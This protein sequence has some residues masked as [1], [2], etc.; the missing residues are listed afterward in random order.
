HS[1]PRPTPPAARTAARSW[2]ATAAATSAS[3]AGAP[4]AA[5]EPL[6]RSTS[7]ASAMRRGLAVSGHEPAK[8]AGAYG[9]FGNGSRV[10]RPDGKIA[11]RS[12]GRSGA[13]I[14]SSTGTVVPCRSLTV[15]DALNAFVN[16]WSRPGGI[17]AGRV[18]FVPKYV[19][20]TITATLR[21]RTA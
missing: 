6:P 18:D 7:E 12:F 4:P 5:A 1:R 14:V 20:T 2:S 21:I 9:T 3:T 8:A 16:D 15:S 19:S 10:G 11:D 17:P 13:R